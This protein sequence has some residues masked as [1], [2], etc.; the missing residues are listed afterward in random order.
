[1][2]LFINYSNNSIIE[3]EIQLFYE[4]II[5]R[6]LLDWTVYIVENYIIHNG[7]ESFV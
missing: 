4:I 6:K 5:L 2:Y 1:M 3:I 7:E